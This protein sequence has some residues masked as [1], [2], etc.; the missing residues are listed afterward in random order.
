MALPLA[1]FSIPPSALLRPYNLP[2]QPVDDGAV[3][4]EGPWNDFLELA[5]ANQEETVSVWG[6]G[7]TD[8][9]VWNILR[10]AAQCSRQQTTSQRR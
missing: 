5:D 9:N 10:A 6:F 7:V 2:L 8:P 3:G 4:E 1:L